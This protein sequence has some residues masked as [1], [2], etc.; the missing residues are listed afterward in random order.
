MAQESSKVTPR[1]RTKF[2]GVISIPPICILQDEAELTLNLDESVL[3]QFCH[4]SGLT[5]YYA[6]TDEYH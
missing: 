5:Y 4:R 2:D 1:L 3:F 6:S